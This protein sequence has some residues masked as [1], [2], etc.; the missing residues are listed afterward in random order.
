MITLERLRLVNWHNFDDAVIDIGSRCLLAGDNGS[1]KST[2]IDAIQYVMAANLRMA[3]FNSAAEE[4]RGGGRDLMGYVR[5]KVGSETSEY[6]RG[7]TVSHIMLEWSGP[8]KG[9]GFSCGVCVE[10]YRD[11]H[12][13]EHF[14]TGGVSIADVSVRGD[15]DAPLMFRQF[16]DRLAAEQK[17]E[18]WENKRLYIRDLTNRLGV[19]KRQA[20]VN[21]YLDSLTRSIGFKP[22]D[23][24]D[25]FV[26]D[27]ILEENPVSIQ[28]MKQNL[29][30][31]K[32]ADREAR[33]ASAK[34]GCLK[35]ICAKAAE[36][37]NYDGL[38]L[39]QEYLK[40]KIEL[41]NERQRKESAAAEL[42]A[43]ENKLDFV[44]REIASLAQKRLDLE[45]E[46]R[47]VDMSLAANDAHRLYEEIN[48]RIGRIKNDLAREEER[49]DNYHSLKAQCEALLGRA[50]SEDFDA[51]NA[52]L[53]EEAKKY[54]DEKYL[55]G[56]QKEEAAEKLRDIRAELADIERGILR[57]PDAP[58]E[59][60]AALEKTG[61][62]AFFLAEAA[63]VIDAAWV[64]AV[65]GWLNTRRFAVL[66]DPAE[67]QVALEVYD[68]LPR[69]VAGAFLPNIAKMR[70]AQVKL[71]SLAEVVKAEGYARLYLDYTLGR[72]MRADIGSLKTYESAVTKE[73]M[74]YTSHTAS[75]I[76]EEVYRRHYLG[77]AALEERKKVLDAEAVE[78][79]AALATAEK[80]EREAAL[81][82]DCCNRVL[83]FLPKLESLFPAITALSALKE[84]LTQAEAELAKLDTQSFRE[85]E[86]R[87][88]ELDGQLELLKTDNDR[89]QTQKGSL[90]TKVE[91]YRNDLDRY[92]QAEEER[93]EAVKTFGGAHPLMLAECEAYA[94]EKLAASTIEKL[95]ATYE[96][97]LTGFKTRT[98]SL[99][100]EYAKL[101]RDYEAEFHYLLG[102]EPG[103]NA[104]AETLLKRLETSELPAYREK[105]ARA[106]E[107]AEKEFKDH[108]ISRLNEH[109]EE[110]KESFN[111]IN[112]ILR[113]MLFGRDQYRFTLEELSERRGQIQ[114]IRE[115]AKIPALEEGGLFA[116]L[117]DPRER[118]AAETLFKKI[119]TSPLDS[120][121]LR[122]ICDYRTYF[123]YD[124]R[125][126][127]TDNIDDATG[128]AV[129][130]SL[131]KVLK[132]KSGGESQTPYYVA[133]AASFY[134]FYK[135]RPENA[136]RLVV[137]DEAF[138]RMDDERIGKI[139]AFYNN[140][141]LQ[142]VI[143]APPEKIEAIGDC[144]TALRLR[145]INI[146]PN[147]DAAPPDEKES[148]LEAA[149]ALEKRGL[150]TLKWEK[151]GEG[152][153]IKTVTC[154]NVE[155]LFEALGAQNPAEA[156][157]CVRAELA[158]L[159]RGTK[160]EWMRRFLDAAIAGIDRARVAAGFLAD[161]EERRRL[162]TAFRFIDAL[163]AAP[164]TELLERV[165]SIRC[166]GD[167]KIFETS[168][169]KRLLDIL[170][171]HADFEDDTPED[172]VLRFIGIARYPE[173]FEFRGPLV[174]TIRDNPCTSRTDFFPLVGGGALST[175]DLD[176]GALSLPQ[177]LERVISIENKA[178][179]FDYLARNNDERELALYHG[180][181][182]SPARGRFFRAVSA[183]MPP[184]CEWRHWGDIDYG[185]FSMLARLRREI[186]PDVRPWRMDTDTLA[187]HRAV[188]VQPAYVERLASLLAE[189][190]LADCRD[191]L[192]YMIEHRVRLEQEALL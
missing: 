7:D 72:V 114:V 144:R 59:L 110:A 23:S 166:F 83:R 130:L 139:L 75:R 179:Y 48:A 39:K 32:E 44:V 18:V 153:R 171:R 54:Q 17:I 117:V 189:P 157:A 155:K 19:W 112:E 82:E 66:V 68:R 79:E 9:E 37:R 136:V 99:K 183:A 165:F 101:V 11:N 86:A 91:N 84:D 168:V 28:D 15:K 49:S 30:N 67:F 20:D 152:E 33:A 89:K 96:A 102:M 125:I 147:F 85:L 184:A 170:R 62:A 94:E 42:A 142:L 93:T 105:I 121:E 2:V 191:V 46:L 69:S 87:R 80:A 51:E 55:A 188:P 150:L 119:L 47:A 10:A 159:L 58:R 178:N 134:R 36:W 63:E 65:E 169:K 60:R 52:A 120:K 22:L 177:S 97:T 113:T 106:Y 137:F 154:D 29:E 45:Q 34:I 173:Y 77:R 111:E 76:K 180:G 53:S 95:S 141:N 192:G 56:K 129:E 57:Y 13:T 181:Q 123:H 25:Q 3:K 88:K 132:E 187:A 160:T 162:F 61:I 27:F 50:L 133:I 161:A 70:G 14:W 98:D 24:I 40:L 167:S 127:E 108:F 118:E 26:C 81:R 126:R 185:G 104:E 151:R 74:T 90:Q 143:S 182:Y 135:G 128:A 73:C 131:S 31:Y 100:K 172:D 64:D 12:Y 8:A 16:R 109:I 6:R 174:F 122:D 71:G 186:R 43:T 176:Q 116:Q 5:C 158:A 115:A 124:I 149:E 4:R 175:V 145:S 41:E 1:G 148:Y 156:A 146:F 92:T 138:N 21:P 78:T 190:L 103:E 35:K 38:I 107:D 164:Q 140:L 163:N